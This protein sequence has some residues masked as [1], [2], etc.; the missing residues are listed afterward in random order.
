MFC[1]VFLVGGKK[2]SYL[3]RSSPWEQQEG[4]QDYYNAPGLLAERVDVLVLETVRARAGMGGS[5]S[6]LFFIRRRSPWVQV[7][8][9]K[10]PPPPSIAR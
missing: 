1:F 10:D 9:L 3:H 4:L 7:Q 8:G 2:A 5:T 6:D